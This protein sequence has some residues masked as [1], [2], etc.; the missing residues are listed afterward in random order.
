[1]ALNFTKQQVFQGNNPKDHKEAI[2]VI[3]S[4]LQLSESEVKRLVENYFNLVLSKRIISK[5]RLKIM[6]LGSFKRKRIPNKFA[7]EMSLVTRKQKKII[8]NI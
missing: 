8:V 6:G 2:K 4:D 7:K 3:A 1:M 5:R